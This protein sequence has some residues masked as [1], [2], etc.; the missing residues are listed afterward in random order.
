MAT[1]EAAAARCGC[2]GSPATVRSKPIRRSMTPTAGSA[3]SSSTTICSAT[4][5]PRWRHPGVGRTLAAIASDHGADCGVRLA[6]DCNALI[7]RLNSLRGR[8]V[9]VLATGDPLWYSVGAKIGR[10]IADENV[11]SV[12][13][14]PVAGNHLKHCLICCISRRFGG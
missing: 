11:V 9:V 14:D 13:L 7:D 10:D 6:P 3:A 8:R 5:S 4:P 12:H 2:F 1:E